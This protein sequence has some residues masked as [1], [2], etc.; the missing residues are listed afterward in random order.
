M[1]IINWAAQPKN[2]YRGIDKVAV[3]SNAT[4]GFAWDGVTALNESPSGA[5]PTKLY[6]DNRN[7]ITL[8]SLE[9]FALTLEAYQVPAGFEPCDGIAKVGTKTSFKALHQS[10]STFTLVYHENVENEDGPIAGGIYHVVFKCKAA[11]SSR[12]HATINDSPEAA[13]LSY[14]ISTTAQTLTVNGTEYPNTAHITIDCTDTNI[15][16]ADAIAGL[17]EILYE[18]SEE[19]TA[20]AIYTYCASL[21]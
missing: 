14:E 6:A 4:T 13:T 19:P 1:A 9:E 8:T 15:W 21:S 12:D 18:D 5:E 17:E 10:R 11:P 16:D 7:Y 3:F 20:A 2:V